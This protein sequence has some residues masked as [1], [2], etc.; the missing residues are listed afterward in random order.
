MIVIMRP[1]AIPEHIAAVRQRIEDEGL[2]STV[3]QGVNKAVIGLIGKRPPGMLARVKVLPGV[4]MVIPVDKPYKFAARGE[5]DGG[6]DSRCVRCVVVLW[7]AHE[8]RAAAPFRGRRGGG[9][10]R[11]PFV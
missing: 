5:G 1:D 8:G 4:E 7:T 3:S 6:D 11:W 10:P 9:K 2:E